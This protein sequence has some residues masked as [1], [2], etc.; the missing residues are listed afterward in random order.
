MSRSQWTWRDGN[1]FLTMAEMGRNFVA[2]GKWPIFSDVFR[3]GISITR[4]IS[5]GRV[6]SGAGIGL[7]PAR[8]YEAQ[9]VSIAVSGVVVG[10]RRCRISEVGNGVE[11]MM[12]ACLLVCVIVQISIGELL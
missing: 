6:N 3:P 4:I 2:D 7:R 10:M 1:R 5:P 12:Y 9:R 8:R 11:R